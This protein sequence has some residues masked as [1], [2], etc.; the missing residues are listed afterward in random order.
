LTPARGVRSGGESAHWS[1]ADIPE[2]E[3]VRVGPFTF[4]LWGLVTAAAVWALYLITLAPTTGWWDTSEYVTTAYIVGLP[5]PPGN[6]LFVMVGRVWIIL[7]E[8]TGMGVAERINFLCATLS[9]AGVYF[10]FLSVARIVA[11]FRVSPREVL[12]AA[13]VASVLGATAFTV[14]T[15]SNLNEKVY[16]LSLFITAAVSYAALRWKDEADTPRGARLLV[17]ITLLMGLGWSNHSMSMLPGFALVVFAMWHRWRALIRPNLIAAGLV[18]LVLG[19]SIQILFPPIRSAQ[20]PIIDE[21]D[22]ECESLVDAITPSTVVDR[23]GRTHLAPACEP[24]ALAIVRDQYVPPPLIPRQ[25]PF[26]QAQLGMYLQYFN[27]QWARSA[28]GGLRA[29]I[30]GLVFGLAAFGL[31]VHARRDRKTFAYATVLLATCTLGLIFALNFKYGY[32]MDSGGAPREVRERDYFYLASFQLW[33]IYAG[34]GLTMMWGRIARALRDRAGVVREELRGPLTAALLRASPVLGVALVPLAFNFAPADRSG[35]NLARDWAYNL[36]QSVEPYAVLFTN[37]DNDTFPLWYAQ[38]VEGVR[39]DVTVIVHSYLGTDWY[40]K[41][42]RQLSAPCQPGQSPES[43]PTTR[44]C[45]RPFDAE[46]AAVPYR[47][48]NPAPPTRAAITWSDEQLDRIRGALR[49]EADT[50]IVVSRDP[51]LEA[52][53]AAG[54]TLIRPD[55]ILH[56]VVQN[57]LGDRPIYFAT[58]APSLF[59]RWGYQPQLV[60]QGL[61]NKLVA[62]P[63][64]EGGLILNARAFGGGAGDSHWFDAGRTARLIDEVYRI[65]E[66]LLLDAWPDP[67]TRTSIPSMYWI[68]H[69]WHYIGMEDRKL[70]LDS[71]LASVEESPSEDA[72]EP[73]SD[74]LQAVRNELSYLERGMAQAARV[75]NHLNVLRGNPG[76]LPV[77]DPEAGD[78]EEGGESADSEEPPDGAPGG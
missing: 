7:L 76:S 56:H 6:P 70:Q 34:I 65:D 47:D 72:L 18:A 71:V 60:R 26:V 50:T 10:W 46:S 3:K 78:P 67:S 20:Q 64:E 41:Q 13:A 35:D 43:S 23:R 15:Q 37:G 29:L 75:A 4:R 32:S 69:L 30:S 58:T 24:L 22:P 39:R 66:I 63:I 17:L 14:W 74:A 51:P 12:V 5:H 31:M 57:V 38:E 53:I 40:P 25:A 49:F 33:G 52:T 16:T 28:P 27:W 2:I 36:L 55:F 61:A 77:Q 21:A 11:H 9:A 45:Q 42:L 1:G 68:M 48:M 44:V 59:M 54:D 19:G 73:D 8:W 62:G